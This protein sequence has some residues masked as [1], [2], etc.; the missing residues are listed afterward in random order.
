MLG[1]HY[2]CGAN[3]GI[4]TYKPPHNPLTLPSIPSHLPIDTQTGSAL[5]AM[6]AYLPQHTT[7]NG[8]QTYNG[9][10]RW[11]TEL[12]TNEHPNSPVLMEGDIHATPIPH[13]SPHQ[14]LTDFCTS[15]YPVGNTLASTFT[16]NRPTL[17][18]WL[19]RLPI[20][21]A[22]TPLPIQLH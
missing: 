5:L 3:R 15:L 2:P 21:P 4:H 11:L 14:P 19:L 18:Q 8:N 12:L 9:T 6:T 13:T 10:L 1:R 16:P 20:Q 7:I 17:D 22:T